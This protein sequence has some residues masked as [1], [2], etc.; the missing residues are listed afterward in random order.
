MKKV[1]FIFIALIFLL[2]CSQSKKEEI[3]IG[4]ILPLT[5][6]MAQYGE[7]LKKGMDLAIENINKQGG[8]NNLLLKVIYEDGQGISKTSVNAFNKIISAEKVPLVIG[9]MF[10]APTLSITPIAEKEKIVL[11]SPTASSIELTSSGDYIFRIYPSDTYDG[12]F[13]ANYTYHNLNIRKVSIIYERVSS[14]TAVSEIFKYNFE[15]YGGEIVSFEGYNSETNNFRSILK[16]ISDDN[17]E[18]IF[19]PGNLNNMVKIL[20]QSKELNI[21]KKFLTISTFYDNKVLELAGNA[22]ENVMFSSPMFDITDTSEQI[23]IIKKLYHEK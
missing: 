13:L 8:I 23:I 3:K 10:S 1:Y 20:I 12:F 22:A 15:N 11:L 5:G 9:C 14:I 21:N 18:L 7:S 19:F 4:A 16:K 17:P 2:S 6:D